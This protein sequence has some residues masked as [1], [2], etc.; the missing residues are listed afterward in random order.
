MNVISAIMIKQLSLTIN[1][2]FDINF[3]E[4]I[5]RIVNHRKTLLHS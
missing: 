3:T 2:L 1:F 4:L 5:M